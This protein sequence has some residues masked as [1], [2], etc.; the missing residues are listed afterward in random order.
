MSGNGPTKREKARVALVAGA[1]YADAAR[2]AGISTRTVRRWMKDHTFRQELQA[3]RRDLLE[4][5][6]NRI[7]GHLDTALDRLTEL[8]HSQSDG[9]SL[10]AVTKV[11]EWS[12]QDD[13]EQR[14]LALEA[15]L[16]EEDTT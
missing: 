7:A 6:R 15:R 4:R 5:A 3:E 1:T 12:M 2:A 10:R 14:L 13:I 9:V 16:P 8:T 11:I